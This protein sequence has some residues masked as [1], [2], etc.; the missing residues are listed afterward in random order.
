MKSSAK[1]EKKA[2]HRAKM[3]KAKRKA[4][5]KR[6]APPNDQT[7]SQTTPEPPRINSTPP[8]EI[9]AVSHNFIRIPDGPSLGFTPLLL[10]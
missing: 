2:A 5:E 7:E 4:R 10:W 1:A 8:L 9:Y 3:K 6:D